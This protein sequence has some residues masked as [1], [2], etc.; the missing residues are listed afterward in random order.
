MAPRHAC[1]LCVRERPEA[2]SVRL[3]PD[4]ELHLLVAYRQ[5]L[6]GDLGHRRFGHDGILQRDI[7]VLT[8]HPVRAWISWPIRAL[9]VCGI[10]AATPA[11][12]M[13][14]NFADV[15]PSPQ[16]VRWQDLEFGVL[17]HF[18]TNTFTGLEW[19]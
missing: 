8:A 16:Q 5:G 6:T 1:R 4:P 19:G 17:V 14:P 13:P 15:L 10:A 11:A 18:G 12:A 3:E 9:L 7:Q 2:R